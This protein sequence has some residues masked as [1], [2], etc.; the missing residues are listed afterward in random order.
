MV[1]NPGHVVIVGNEKGGS[2]K[3]TVAMH[4]AIGFLQAGRKVAT[5][6]LD[7][8]QSTLTRYVANRR[9]YTRAI[10]KDV[11][12]PDHYGGEVASDLSDPKD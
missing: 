4:L 3:S 9:L 12:M 11:V 7:T 2:G 1:T 5:V 10:G 8:R 6:D